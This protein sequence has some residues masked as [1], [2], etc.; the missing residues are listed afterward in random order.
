MEKRARYHAFL[1]SVELLQSLDELERDDVADNL[2]ALSF[3][4]NQLIVEQGAAGDCMYFVESG[5]VRC[6]QREVPVPVQYSYIQYVCNTAHCTL[7]LLYT[8]A[9]RANSR[10]RAASA[11]WHA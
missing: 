3:E 10:R 6:T 9:M 11:R 2:Q 1:K 7:H 5:E 8:A 4:H